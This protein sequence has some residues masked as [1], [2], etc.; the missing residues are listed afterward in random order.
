[1]SRPRRAGVSKQASAGAAPAPTTCDVCRAPVDP[2]EAHRPHEE[3]CAGPPCRCD[4]RTHPGCCP[5][6][7]RPDPD[8]DR[9]VCRGEVVFFED[10]DDGGRRG[11]GCEA[12]G[13]VFAAV[14]G[15]D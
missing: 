10:G 14:E 12:G 9:C 8:S 5:T 3:L 6:C 2:D 7:H 11:L 15:E 4:R 1:V 13:R